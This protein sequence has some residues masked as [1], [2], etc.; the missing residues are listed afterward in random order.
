MNLYYNTT[1]MPTQYAQI[2]IASIN[3]ICQRLDEVHVP[4]SRTQT[5]SNL[6]YYSIP[7]FGAEQ[8]QRLMLILFYFWTKVSRVSFPSVLYPAFDVQPQK[9][10]Q[11]IT[12]DL[13]RTTLNFGFYGRYVQLQKIKIQISPKCP[14][15]KK[16]EAK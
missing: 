11:L 16:S 4:D 1:Y 5:L 9:D 2:K 13:P 8:Q 12:T 6:C 10:I 3:Y 15:P 7:E 14:V